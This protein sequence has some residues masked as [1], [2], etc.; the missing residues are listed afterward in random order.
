MHPD[1]LLSRGVEKGATSFQEDER[2]WLGH[3]LQLKPL[4]HL[5]IVFSLS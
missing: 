2:F 5:K 1:I 3:L 4:G